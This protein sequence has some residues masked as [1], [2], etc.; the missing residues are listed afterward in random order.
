MQAVSTHDYLPSNHFHSRSVRAK[1]GWAGGLLTLR[2]HLRPLGRTGQLLAVYH[3]GSFGHTPPHTFAACSA[4]RPPC[5]AIACKNRSLTARVLTTSGQQ[6][7]KQRKNEDR[8]ST[9]S[10]YKAISRYQ[11]LRT[12]GQTDRRAASCVRSGQAAAGSF[13][14]PPYLRYR[15]DP[16]TLQHNFPRHPTLQSLAPRFQN[17]C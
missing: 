17:P 8:A 6:G 12:N 11:R 16:Q 4:V 5:S 2:G 13:Q 3:W 14:D 1:D 10:H 15:E 9:V 7:H